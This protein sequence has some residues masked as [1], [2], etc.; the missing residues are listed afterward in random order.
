LG[1]ALWLA[2]AVA[3]LFISSLLVIV[4]LLNQLAQLATEIAG[5]IGF[6]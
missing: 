1:P 3:V 5:R 4:L 2:A 6:T